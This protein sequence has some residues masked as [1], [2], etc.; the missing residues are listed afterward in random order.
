[1]LGAIVKTFDTTGAASVMFP[2]TAAHAHPTAKVMGYE[3]GMFAFA[4]RVALSRSLTRM[5]IKRRGET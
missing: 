2:T 5:W 4:N 3:C 1:L